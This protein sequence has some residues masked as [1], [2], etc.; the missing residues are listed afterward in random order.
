MDKR[1]V[2]K[3]GAMGGALEAC[4]NFCPV[5]EIGGDI[6]NCSYFKEWYEKAMDE[7]DKELE[8]MESRENND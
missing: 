4:I 3:V 8:E 2:N 1:D 7:Y 5:K 6:H